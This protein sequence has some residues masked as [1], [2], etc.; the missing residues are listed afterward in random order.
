LAFWGHALGAYVAP[1][2][3]TMPLVIFFMS[4]GSLW[5]TVAAFLEPLCSS[6]IYACRLIC[7]LTMMWLPHTPLQVLLPSLVTVRQWLG[8]AFMSMLATGNS[9]SRWVCRAASP[10]TTGSPQ[11]RWASSLAPCP[12]DLGD[13]Y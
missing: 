2:N 12:V 6:Y 9:Q 7:S 8:A 13:N 5:Y 1:C 3:A 11:R 10:L 4:F